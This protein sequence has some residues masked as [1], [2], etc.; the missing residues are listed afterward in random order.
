MRM[1]VLVSVLCFTSNQ[2][3]Q[4]GGQRELPM[5]SNA[6]MNASLQEVYKRKVVFYVTDNSAQI[7]IILEPK[8]ALRNAI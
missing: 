5:L 7:T 6:A 8:E 1:R 3:I 2:E 4:D